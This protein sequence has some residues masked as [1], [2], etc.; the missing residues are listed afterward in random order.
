MRTWRIQY[1]KLNHY[2]SIRVLLGLLTIRNLQ[3]IYFRHLNCDILTKLVI[4]ASTQI[5]AFTATC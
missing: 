5:P 4:S 1:C 3:V 2:I